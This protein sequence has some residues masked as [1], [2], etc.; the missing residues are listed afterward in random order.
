MRHAGGSSADDWPQNHV[1]PGGNGILQVPEMLASPPSAQTQAPAGPQPTA[2]PQVPAQSSAQAQPKPAIPGP[3]PPVVPA[4]APVPVAAR[5]P[6]L[7]IIDA[8]RLFAAMFVALHH[9]A[10]TFRVNQPHNA[11]WGR[12]VQ[13]I[14]PGVFRI[15]AY[16][17][18]GVEIFFV[19]SG[20]VICMSCW[21][22]RPRDFFVSRVI[23]LYPAYW[24]GIILT[25][26]V[27]TIWPA[28]WKPLP[29]RDVIYTCRCSRRV[30][31]SPT[32][33]ASTGRCSPSCAST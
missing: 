1:S 28:V 10:G 19:I 9:Y 33:T 25:T 21:D 24:F 13:D 3:I 27:L 32:W 17:W 29:K 2:M 5:R 7:Y 4:P 12:P 11:V 16:G 15:S 23:R 8:L 18:V 31:T 14:M 6:R 26:V 22:R 20:F 30:R